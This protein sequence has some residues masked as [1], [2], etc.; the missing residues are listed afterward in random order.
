MH[1]GIWK[2]FVYLCKVSKCEIYNLKN[3]A[4]YDLNNVRL[5]YYTCNLIVL[6]LYIYF[7]VFFRAYLDIILD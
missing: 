6:F 2:K 1:F 5:S 7:K 3:N 4:K